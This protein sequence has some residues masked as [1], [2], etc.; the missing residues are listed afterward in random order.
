MKN[1]IYIAFL[2][3][4]G[5]GC[6]TPKSKIETVAKPIATK[7]DTVRI[8]NDELKYEVI[9]IDPGFNNWLNTRALPRSYYTKS[10]LESKNRLYVS[11]W[12]SRVLQSQ[13]Y[14]SNL[15]ERT[16]DY[17]FST[18]YGFEVNYLIYN[19]MVYFQNTY[20][21]KLRGNVPIR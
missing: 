21:Q 10:F 11:E 13:R 5:I 6:T 4:I 7:N 16:I 3:L 19:Y 17:N 14:N 2:F 20:K 12:N 9:I 15:Y 8:A 1:S 18:D